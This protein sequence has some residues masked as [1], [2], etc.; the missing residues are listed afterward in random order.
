MLDRRRE[1]WDRLEGDKRRTMAT[2]DPLNTDP[3][4]QA[5]TLCCL[6]A[7]VTLCALRLSVRISLV[8]SVSMAIAVLLCRLVRNRSQMLAA[9]IGVALIGCSAL[10]ASGGSKVLSHLPAGLPS[11]LPV[12]VTVSN[13]GALWLIE[14]AIPPLGL[15]LSLIA[16]VFTTGML[17]GSFGRRRGFPGR[18]VLAL[19]VSA[20]VTLV[21]V[22]LAAASAM[23]SLAGSG[24]AQVIGPEGPVQAAVGLT[25]QLM[26]EGGVLVIALAS[27]A[28]LRVDSEP[29]AERVEREEIVSRIGAGNVF[30]VR[31]TAVSSILG[32]LA[33]GVA[34]L[35]D[36]SLFQSPAPVVAY[37]HVFLTALAWGASWGCVFG[38]VESVL[39]THRAAWADAPRPVP[40]APWL[41][42]AFIVGA[43]VV[44]AVA[45]RI[46]GY[47]IGW[48]SGLLNLLAPPSHVHRLAAES[49]RSGSILA[50]FLAWLS[51]NALVWK[52]GPGRTSLR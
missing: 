6:A 46:I 2:S 32:A 44:G 39:L 34:V 8:A 27:A 31:C 15:A 50:G 16:S 33:G 42:L 38:L 5:W 9:Q 4:K 35:M 1:P 48:T 47:R 14:H 40:A 45:G 17:A 36:P 28:T 49:A 10:A 43:T 23:R 11:F 7:A 20:P 22:G 26:R 3:S 29:R 30:L 24:L 37:E 19:L 18:V 51:A 13:L 12:R 52:R 41:G 21:V 25:W